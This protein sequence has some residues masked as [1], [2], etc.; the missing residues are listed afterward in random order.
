[1]QTA[2]ETCDRIYVFS[3]LSFLNGGTEQLMMRTVEELNA[4]GVP[5]V[6]CAFRS[7]EMMREEARRRGV[8]LRVES[9]NYTDQLAYVASLAER[10]RHVRVVTYTYEEYLA[11]ATA[12]RP[13]DGAHGDVTVLLYVAARYGVLNFGDEFNTPEGVARDARVFADGSRRGRI[14]FMDDDTLAYAREHYHVDLPEARDRILLL[15]FAAPALDDQ[16]LR[17][18]TRIPGFPILAIARA[19]FPFK[20]YLFELVDEVRRLAYR[21]VDCSLTMIVGRVGNER[22]YERLRRH[23]GD[24]P[25][26]RL[27]TDVPHEDLNGYYD[28]ARL[29]VGMG[30]TVL[31]AA[32]RGVPTVQVRSNTYDLYVTGSF[33]DAPRCIVADERRPRMPFGDIARRLVAMDDAAYLQACARTRTALDE[34]YSTGRYV[35][36]IE[37]TFDGMTS[38]EDSL[39][40]ERGRSKV[41][42]MDAELIGHATD[43]V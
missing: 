1:M 41:A 22:G 3:F 13:A 6:V 15:P 32:A 43:V 2:D 5:S 7:N 39:R 33:V 31:E 36:A 9:G 28:A 16:T 14:V 35:D 27:V 11:C 30:T 24:H 38:Y 17:A 19:D 8:R 10:Y 18:R 37:A 20:G 42:I 12:E 34:V 40:A 29:Y 25:R 4:R 21:G 23:V 26:V